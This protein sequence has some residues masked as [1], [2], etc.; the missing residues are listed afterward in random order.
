MNRNK[1]R[2]PQARA[3][4]S[5]CARGQHVTPNGS[6]RTV[7]CYT[8]PYYIILMRYCTTSKH[9]LSYQIVPYGTTYQVCDTVLYLIIAYRSLRYQIVPDRTAPYTTG[10]Y[11]TIPYRINLYRTAP[12]RAVYIRKITPARS[13]K[14]LALNS[15]RQRYNRHLTSYRKGLRARCTPCGCSP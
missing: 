4:P 5:T 11:R 12:N 1:Q 2:L 14:I 7:P 8:V 3:Q 6:Y 9:T 15:I 13:S 10:S